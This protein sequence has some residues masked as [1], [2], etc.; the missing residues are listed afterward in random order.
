[1]KPPHYPGETLTNGRLWR[2]NTRPADPQHTWT[3]THK[4]TLTPPSRL[5]SYTGPPSPRARAC[6]WST[7][8]VKAHWVT[9]VCVCVRQRGLV[10]V[11]GPN[12]K[13]RILLRYFLPS[14]PWPGEP[15]PKS[16]LFSWPSTSPLPLPV[17]LSP[18]LSFFLTFF[19]LSPWTSNIY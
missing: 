14:K 8:I 1:M 16:L 10:G 7:Y 15:Q 17:S 13:C 6:L 3:T 19:S 11:G 5:I 12:L 18:P 2:N 4:L 9:C